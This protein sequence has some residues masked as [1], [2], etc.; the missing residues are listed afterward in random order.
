MFR[1]QNQINTLTNPNWIGAGQDWALAAAQE[2]AEAIDHHGWKWWK[3]VE[4]V[5]DMDQLR[6]EQ[7]DVFHFM[8]SAFIELGNEMGVMPENIFISECR[9]DVIL[10]DS[11]AYKLADMTLIQKLKLQAGLAYANRFEPAL[12]ASIAVDIDLPSD[13]LYSM[14]LGKNVLNGFRQNNG[15]KEGNYIKI[16]ADGREDNQ[17]LQQILDGLA[18]TNTA[19]DETILYE[20]LNDRYHAVNKELLGA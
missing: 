2:S 1:L 17:H 11:E 9:D 18:E 20:F 8:L 14:Y 5:P 10:F 16:W 12:F 4:Q 7:V 3:N 15:Y 19:Y 6:M 13:K